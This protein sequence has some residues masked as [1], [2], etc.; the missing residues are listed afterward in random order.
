MTMRLNNLE[1]RPGAK[2]RTKRYGCGQSS[3]HG[4]TSGRGGK[5]QTARSGS[6]IRVGFEGG[7][8]PLIRRMPKRG[9]NNAAF[10]RE[11]TIVSV[12]ALNPLPEGTTVT[13]ELLIESGIIKS[14][15][16]GLKILGGGKLTK[17]L[18]VRA[19]KFSGTART[20][21]EAAGGTCEVIA[22]KRRPAVAPTTPKVQETT[23]K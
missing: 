23:E 1:N 7:Q 12:E 5:G 14:A 15:D 8:M 9:F 17:K 16:Q 19:H 11:F 4:G 18:T 20:S 6:G 2:R 22:E 3:G 21:I 10:R 13:P